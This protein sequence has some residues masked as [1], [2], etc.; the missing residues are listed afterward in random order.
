M[1]FDNFGITTNGYTMIAKATTGVLMTFQDGRASS[2]TI[3]QADIASATTS[4]FSTLTNGV[5]KALSV[6]GSA[7]QAIIEFSNAG[8]QSAVTL[9]S[10]CIR[11]HSSDSSSTNYVF[12]VCSINTG[13]ITLQPQSVTGVEVRFQIPF[14]LTFTGAS[15]YIEGIPVGNNASVDMLNRFVSLHSLANPATGDAQTILGEK[16]F[17]DS[18]LFEDDVEIRGTAS[19]R[20]VIPYENSN[21]L[22]ESGRRFGD[23]W[24]L[25][26]HGAVPTASVV[27]NVVEAEVGSIMCIKRASPSTAYFSVGYLL[28]NKTTS[29]WNVSSLDGQ[30]YGNAPIGYY[31]VISPK[32]AAASSSDT[33][34]NKPIL[35]VYLGLGLD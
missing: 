12:A 3:S 22:G 33:E 28:Y 24:A 27:N 25:A 30:V 4:D 29:A 13:G 14:D 34:G 7:V 16:T 20:D 5:L 35:V 32:P 17:S 11:A 2:N 15:T 10:F 8:L 1:A 31:R 23:V 18:A 26:L 6:T 9:K 21:K 19:C